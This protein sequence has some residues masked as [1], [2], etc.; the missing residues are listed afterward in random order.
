MYVDQL[1][2]GKCVSGTDAHG[3]GFFQTVSADPQQ[4]SEHRSAWCG[5]KTGGTEKELE[6]ATVQ[7]PSRLKPCSAASRPRSKTCKI[8]LLEEIIETE[9][10]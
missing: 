10:G 4:V 6:F 8:I 1:F 2:S 9:H 7:V 3:S 5:R